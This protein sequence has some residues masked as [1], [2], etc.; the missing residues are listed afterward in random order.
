MVYTS[1]FRRIREKKTNYRK[2]EK[3]LVGKKDFVT[4]NVS[5]QNISAQ[6][7]RPDLL[8]DKVMA[9]VHSNELLSYGWKGSRKNIP[10]CYLVGLLL[11]KKC[12][13]KKISSAILYIGKRHFTTK[14]AACLKGLSEAGMEMPFSE[15]ILPSEDRIQGNHI[16][17]YA[18]KLKANEDVYKSRFS[19]NLGSGLEPEKYPSHF[20]EIKDKIVNDKAKKEKES[21]KTP[22]TTIKTKSK[23]KLSEKKGDSK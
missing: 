1:T 13:Q 12:L 18:K 14:I 5:D 8:G 15:N 7:I 17:D 4:V 22:K 9:S 3:L 6:L 21:E 23:S 16:A 11:G 2:R 20:S 10:S 19:S